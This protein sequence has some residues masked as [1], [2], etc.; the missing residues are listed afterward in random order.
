[1]V[2][3]SV[4]IHGI[5]PRS[6]KLI[7]LSRDF[8]R[9]RASF[10]QLEKQQQKDRQQLINFQKKLKFEFVEDG[11]FAWQDIFRPFTDH[12]QGIKSGSLTR[13]FDNNTF[14]RQPIIKGKV[15][16]NYARILNSFYFDKSTNKVTL[17]SFF[18]LAKVSQNNYYR[19][20]LS[21][22]FAL[23][24]EFKILAQK[25]EKQGITFIQLNDPYLVYH[26]INKKELAIY[27]KCLKQFRQGLKSKIALH[28]FFGSID[29]YFHQLIN[30]PIDIL[31][32]DC[33]KTNLENLPKIKI[34]K[35]LLLG[36]L[37]SRSLV[38]E[39]KKMVK[40][41]IAQVQEKFAPPQIYLSPNCDLEFLTADIAYKKIKLLL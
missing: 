25:L 32:F 31:G 41:L 30:F 6:E 1:M 13:Y 11:K 12:S 21:L 19:N 3:V 36:C 10:S 22:V 20:F 39:N 28:T 5:F 9:Q 26:K 35:G 16:F 17:P 4:F 29:P 37:D 18:Y 7:Q 34:E 27:Q 23:T 33:F 38:L 2:K 15:K 24:S 14:F 40:K 8:D